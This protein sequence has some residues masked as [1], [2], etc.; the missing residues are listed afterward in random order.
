MKILG[1]TGGMG[2]GKTTVAAMLRRAGF[3]VFDSDA[4]V[5]RLQGPNGKAVAAMG[6]LVPAALMTDCE[7]RET[8]DRQ[9]LRK[10][11]MADSK[12][13]HDFEKIIH[14]LVFE[15]RNEFLKHYRRKGSAWV[16]LDV[17][18]LF[19]TGGHRKCDKVAVVSAPRRTQ[20]KRIARRRGMTIP[21]AERMIARQMPDREKRCRADVVIHTGLSKA[22]TRRQVRT[23]I[24]EMRG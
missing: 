21:E 2:M 1:L 17:P 20:A 9:A 13:I 7:G 3:P 10:A 24:R 12:L 8:L 22:D 5:H 16:V 23:L 14:P 18:L 6:R 19:E 11:V 15:A 4:T